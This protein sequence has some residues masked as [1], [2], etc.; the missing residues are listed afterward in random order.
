MVPEARQAT[1]SS[2]GNGQN[3]GQMDAPTEE[4]IPFIAELAKIAQKGTP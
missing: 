2:M 4:K 3:P 1:I